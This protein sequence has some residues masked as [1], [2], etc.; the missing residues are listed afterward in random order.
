MLTDLEQAVY[1]MAV[2]AAIGG[3]R[4]DTVTD[5]C[6]ECG[7]HLTRKY[8]DYHL[9]VPMPDTDPK[10]REVAV[11]VGCEGYWAVNPALVGIDRPTWLPHVVDVGTPPPGAG[12]CLTCLEWEADPGTHPRCA[13]CGRPWD[14]ITDDD[15][16]QACGNCGDRVATVSTRGWCDGCE[17]EAEHSG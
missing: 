12:V 9:V 8:H 11:V 3:L 6:P 5:L 2:A 1:V 14:R 4:P 13:R 16:L 10:Q 7:A 15:G 17:E